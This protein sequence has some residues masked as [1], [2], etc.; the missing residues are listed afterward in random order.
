M[1]AVCPFCGGEPEDD[2]AKQ[3]MVWYVFCGWC[4]CGGPSGNSP[5]QAI[6]KWNERGNAKL[7]DDVE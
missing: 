1:F 7:R 2:I 3:G 5:S 6:Q 4:G